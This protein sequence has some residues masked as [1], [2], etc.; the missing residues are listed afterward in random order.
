[1][2]YKVKFGDIWKL[3]NHR[4]LCGDSIEPAMMERFLAGYEPAICVTDPPYGVNYKT[5]TSKLALH[6][7][8]VKNDHVVSWGDAFK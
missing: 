8:R 7:L 3:G 5:R 4:L 1:M 2:N 6:D